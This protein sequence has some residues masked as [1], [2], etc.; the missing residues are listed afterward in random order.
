MFVSR[1]W[2]RTQTSTAPGLHLQ[3]VV[4]RVRASMNLHT[5]YLY[6][7]VLNMKQKHIIKFNVLENRMGGSAGTTKSCK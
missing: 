5:G 1:L 2:H 7:F 3:T 6:I 4:Y